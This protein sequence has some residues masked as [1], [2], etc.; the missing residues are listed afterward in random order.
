MPL[1]ELEDGSFGVCHN[2]PSFPSIH[3]CPVL[4]VVHGET[5]DLVVAVH[6]ADRQPREGTQLSRLHSQR[7]RSCLRPGLFRRSPDCEL[8]SR[9]QPDQTRVRG[10]DWQQAHQISAGRRA[11]WQPARG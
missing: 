4:H 7:R 6:P 10:E 11:W 2:L 8:C 3:M 9:R 5:V 1:T